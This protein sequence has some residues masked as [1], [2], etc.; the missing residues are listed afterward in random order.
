MQ[1]AAFLIGR[2]AGRGVG[3]VYNLTGGVAAWAYQ[4]DDAFPTY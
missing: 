3:K 4:V 2:I 1:A